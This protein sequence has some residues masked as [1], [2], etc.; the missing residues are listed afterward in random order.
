MIDSRMC[1]FSSVLNLHRIAAE[2]F[3]F[4]LG[5]WSRFSRKISRGSCFPIEEH[6]DGRDCEP[7]GLSPRRC[8]PP[9]GTG[10]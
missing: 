5:K 1:V 4:V 6:Q 8:L 10:V 2:K 9:K 3:L 7:S